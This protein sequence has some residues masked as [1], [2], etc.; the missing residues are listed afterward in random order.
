MKT[1]LNEIKT[2]LLGDFDQQGLIHKF[3]AFAEH[4]E[5]ELKDLKEQFYKSQEAQNR[6]I[7]KIKPIL[8]LIGNWKFL[9]GFFVG[10]SSFIYTLVKL[11]HYIRVNT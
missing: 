11:V 1:E 6:E 9:I 5:E 7:D 3:N 4:V 2:A 8:D 10:L